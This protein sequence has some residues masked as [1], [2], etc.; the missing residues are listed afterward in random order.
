[1]AWVQDKKGV[2][3]GDGGADGYIWIDPEAEMMVKI[4]AGTD[5][6]EMTASEAREL[7]ALLNRLADELDR[8]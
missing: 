5:P 7:A 6:V 1:M 3:L 4:V 8:T 2:W